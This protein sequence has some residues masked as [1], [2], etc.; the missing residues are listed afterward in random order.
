MARHRKGLAT[1]F[2]H[3]RGVVLP[4][5]KFDTA[6]WDRELRIVVLGLAV[7]TIAAFAKE[8]ADRY[9]VKVDVAQLKPFLDPYARITAEAA[10][11][12]TRE[13]LREAAK[14]D[15]PKAA[16]EHV[17]EVAIGSRALAMA[18]SKVTT[19]ANLGRDYAAKESDVTEKRWVV[20]SGRPRTEHASINGET[21]GLGETF[22]NGA[23]WPGDPSLTV[24]QRA[25]C[26]CIVDFS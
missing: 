10:N 22:S 15:D 20:T 5:G 1:F 9:G 17:F 3:Q 21:V 26:S 14:T 11:A 18:E 24:D 6:R 23:E 13:R 7:P 8:I 12:H 2:A 19:E 16:A 25:N 4:A